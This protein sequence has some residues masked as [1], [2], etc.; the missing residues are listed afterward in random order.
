MTKKQ[1]FAVAKTLDLRCDAYLFATKVGTCGC[2]TASKNYGDGWVLLTLFIN[3]IEK[4]MENLNVKYHAQ[5]RKLLIHSLLEYLREE[6]PKPVSAP[7]SDKERAKRARHSEQVI[8][9][10]EEALK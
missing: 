9:A 10:I 2:I 3:L 8:A 1:A 6:A 4:V 5:F 7:L